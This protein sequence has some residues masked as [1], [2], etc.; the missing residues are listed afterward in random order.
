VEITWGPDLSSKVDAAALRI[1]G[2]ELYLL[3]LHLFEAWRCGVGRSVLFLIPIRSI[4]FL[5][6]VELQCNVESLLLLFQEG[7]QEHVPDFKKQ[8][9]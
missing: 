3:F 9:T 4:L 6:Q 2:V 1:P 7:L 5:M 8:S